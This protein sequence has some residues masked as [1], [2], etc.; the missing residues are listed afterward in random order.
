MADDYEGR[1]KIYSMIKL[2]NAFENMFKSHI[3]GGKIANE[4]LT[5]LES[6]A[7]DNL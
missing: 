3:A 1:E 5:K 2:S 4:M 6:G 7:F